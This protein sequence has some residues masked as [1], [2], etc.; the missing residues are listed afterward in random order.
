MLV[1]GILSPTQKKPSYKG[2]VLAP[3]PLTPNGLLSIS[4]GSWLTVYVGLCPH[5]PIALASLRVL[6][7]RMHRSADGPLYCCSLLTRW[8]SAIDKQI[9]PSLCWCAHQPRHVVCIACHNRS[10]ERRVGKECRSRW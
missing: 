3:R 7:L 1:H 2:P 10:E 4:C 5:L 8:V 6:P 9:F